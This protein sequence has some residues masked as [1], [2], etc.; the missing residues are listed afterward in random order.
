M[1]ILLCL[2]LQSIRLI[3]LLI[4]ILTSQSREG[5]NY[6]IYIYRTYQRFDNGTLKKY[7]NYTNLIPCTADRFSKIFQKK[8]Q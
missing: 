7:E 2:P 8:G 6:N 5:I 1:T 4:P 3:L